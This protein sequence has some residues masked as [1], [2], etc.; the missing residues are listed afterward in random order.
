MRLYN[1][2]SFN[3]RPVSPLF[4]LL[5][6][7]LWFL[8]IHN[9]WKYQIE[10]YQPVLTENKI[11]PQQNL[12][13]YQILKDISR[14]DLQDCFI[15]KIEL[16]PHQL[17]IYGKGLQERSIALITHQFQ[18]MSWSNQVEVKQW[19]YITTGKWRFII[20]VEY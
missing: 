9:I 5:I 16:Y 10:K 4:Y 2:L 19:D 1:F 11:K 18:L 12:Q 7:L 13:V 6:V 20:G 15:K 8:S 14:V 3:L 17:L